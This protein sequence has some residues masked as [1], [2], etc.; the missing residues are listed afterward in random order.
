MIED[1][2][3]LGRNANLAH[4]CKKWTDLRKRVN[5]SPARPP[6]SPDDGLKPRSTRFLAAKDITDIVRR[7]EAGETTQQI[8]GCYGISKTGVATI[9]RERGVTI[10]RQS[11]MLYAAG[12]SLAWL[13]ARFDVSHTTVATTLRRTPMPV[14]CAASATPYALLP[15]VRWSWPMPWPRPESTDTH[16]LRSQPC[17]AP[18]AKPLRNATASPPSVGEVRS[19]LPRPA[20]AV[21]AKTDRGRCL[22]IR[23]P[24]VDHIPSQRVAWLLRPLLMGSPRKRTDRHLRAQREAPS[25]NEVQGGPSKDTQAPESGAQG[26]RTPGF[27][28]HQRL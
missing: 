5:E 15:A 26:T 12:R 17:S 18:A 4:L 11:L 13:G 27:G 19:I 20:R 3:A 8:S 25:Q 23:R 6:S 22:K 24:G 10:R 1:A 28:V 7:H 9:L 16:G 14:G 21:A 2:G